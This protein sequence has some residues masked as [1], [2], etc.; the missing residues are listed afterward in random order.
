MLAISDYNDLTALED[1]L[2][3]TEVT[4]HYRTNGVEKREEVSR[5]YCQGTHVRIVMRPHIEVR[6]C[7]CSR[8][9]SLEEDEPSITSIPL[10]DVFDVVVD[11]WAPDLDSQDQWLPL[12]F[13]RWLRDRFSKFVRVALN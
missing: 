1:D 7:S 12:P 9:R 6:Q 13:A 11:E 8:C 3:K 2:Q 4:I 10:E 5:S